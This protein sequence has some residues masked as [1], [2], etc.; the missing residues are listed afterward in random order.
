MSPEEMLTILKSLD[1]EL[2]N[3]ESIHPDHRKSLQSLTHE[4]QKKLASGAA[5]DTSSSPDGKGT[6]TLS[7]QM[8]DA[9]VEFEVRH[10]I[11]GGLV[12]RM[13]DGLSAMGI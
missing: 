8:K 11:I 13:A 3:A 9:V 4:I 1:E 10:P 2:E 5:M 6:A 7:Q 12:E